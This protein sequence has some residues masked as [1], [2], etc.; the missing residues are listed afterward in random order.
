MSTHA[1]TVHSKLN[2]ARQFCQIPNVKNRM[3]NPSLA[4]GYMY[5]CMYVHMYDCKNIV[6]VC[7]VCIVSIYVLY[8]LG[9]QVYTNGGCL[10]YLVESYVR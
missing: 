9:F 10:L 7:K 4:Q 6:Y 8:F 3:S 1:S 5:I 2:N